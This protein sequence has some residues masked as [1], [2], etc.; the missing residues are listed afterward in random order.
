MAEI[1][2]RLE[3]ASNMVRNHLHATAEMASKWYNHKARP[4]S[5]EPGIESEYII[6]ILSLRGR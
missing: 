6:H 3:R 2:E 4:R 5:F 1:V